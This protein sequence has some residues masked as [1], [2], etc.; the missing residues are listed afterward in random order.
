MM[1]KVVIKMVMLLHKCHKMVMLLHKC[2][3]GVA[4]A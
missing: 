4:K 3:K 2:H 1:I